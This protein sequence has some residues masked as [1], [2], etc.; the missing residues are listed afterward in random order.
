MEARGS[1]NICLSLAAG[2][3]M[4]GMWHVASQAKLP[5]HQGQFFREGGSCEPL[6]AC[7]QQLGGGCTGLGG[8]TPAVSTTL[9]NLVAY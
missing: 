3:G 2:L 7:S 1:A 6:A 8:G 4:E 5:F 9:E